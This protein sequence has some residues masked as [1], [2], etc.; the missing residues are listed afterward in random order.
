MDLAD[1]IT[2]LNTVAFT[3][4][5]DGAGRVAL[6]GDEVWLNLSCQST[7]IQ[8]TSKPTLDLVD[9]TDS[10]CTIRASKKVREE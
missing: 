8:D 4:C 3:I 5:S 6:L 10:C 1:R 9:D 2:V 7:L